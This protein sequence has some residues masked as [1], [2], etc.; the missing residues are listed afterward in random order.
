M[1]ALS[2]EF[3]SVRRRCLPWMIRRRLAKL[4]KASWIRV[5]VA[6]VMEMLP[7]LHDIYE[8]LDAAT[9][10]ADLLLTHPLPL[11]G[12]IVAQKK[13]LRWVS[14]VLAGFISFRIRSDSPA[15][16]ARSVQG[17]ALALGRSRVMAL[18]T[19][20]LDKICS[21]LRRARRIGLAAVSS[22][23]WAVNIRRLC[24]GAFSK[25]LA[26]PQLIGRN[27]VVTGFPFY[28]RRTFG[29]SQSLKKSLNFWG[30]EPPIVFTLGSSAFCG[31]KLLSRFHRSGE[32]WEARV[33]AHRPCAQ[34]AAEKLPPGLRHSNTRLTVKS[35]RGL[36]N[37]S[38][39][40]RGDNG[41][42]CVQVSPC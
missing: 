33:V 25:V 13:R 22:Q 11:L 24:A 26:S 5:S 40:R 15:A 14:S 16:M 23:F 19:K 20:K 27:T 31:L 37:R 12:P 38:S 29:E 41:Q 17:N 7:Y 30:G 3:H 4:S 34:Y 6:K 2:I 32:A 36:R 8:D 9:E 10:G 35:C 28:D 42:G 1:D 18:A 21:G 39:G